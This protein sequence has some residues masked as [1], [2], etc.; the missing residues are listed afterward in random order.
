MP[1]HV[2]VL[3]LR[4][5]NMYTIHLLEH[6]QREHLLRFLSHMFLVRIMLYYLSGML[7]LAISFSNFPIPSSRVFL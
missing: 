7:F 5:Y 3:A 6:T 1:D 4:A 2:V